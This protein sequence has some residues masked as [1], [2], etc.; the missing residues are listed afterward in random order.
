MACAERTPSAARLR[1]DNG[2]LADEHW[3]AAPCLRVM[4]QRITTFE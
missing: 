2:Y 1:A 3:L 4:V